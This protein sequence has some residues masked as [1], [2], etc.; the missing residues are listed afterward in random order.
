MVTRVSA[1]PTV[2]THFGRA[3]KPEISYWFDIDARGIR[4]SS[5]PQRVVQVQEVG[6][7]PRIPAD[8]PFLDEAA[9]AKRGSAIEALTELQVADRALARQIADAGIR[10]L[11]DKAAR[12][13]IEDARRK[14]LNELA[15]IEAK[16][17]TAESFTRIISLRCHDPAD[18]RSF[19]FYRGTVWS[20]SRELEPEQWRILVDAYVAREEAEFA[21]ALGFL[22][23]SQPESR[24]A[25]TTAVRRAVWARDNGRCAKCGSRERLEYDHIIPVSKGGSNTERNI[26]L[27]CETC[28]RAKSDAIL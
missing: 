25:I 17:A 5:E 6:G 4:L 2:Q 26:E 11:N 8:R 19:A 9:R 12:G 14:T 20:C 3:E 23:E 27:L 21:Q 24:E 13:H 7:S 16:N 28:N 15:Y 18:E 22:P 1:K 10:T